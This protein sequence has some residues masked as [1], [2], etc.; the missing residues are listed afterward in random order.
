[1]LQTNWESQEQGANIP[2]IFTILAL[3]KHH[4]AQT[5]ENRMLLHKMLCL[6]A[7]PANICLCSTLPPLKNGTFTRKKKK[8]LRF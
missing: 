2:S 6:I 5:H 4:S 7:S 8:L 1:M 3:G